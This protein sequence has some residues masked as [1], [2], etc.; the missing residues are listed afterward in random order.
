MSPTCSTM[1][2][3]ALFYPT[4]VNKVYCYCY[5]EQTHCA[6]VVYIYIYMCVIEWVTTDLCSTFWISI[7]VVVSLF[8]FSVVPWLVPCQTAPVLAQ[9]L[10]TP[11][12][13]EPLYTTVSLFKAVYIRYVCFAVTCYAHFWQNDQHPL[14]AI[15]LARRWNVYWSNSQHRKL[16]LE[17]KILLPLLPGL[18]PHDLSI[19]NLLL[20]QWAIPAP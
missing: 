2:T 7:K 9:V 10:C 15:A 6:L 16:T 12:N 1:A 4:G 17:K 13:H 19:T 5:A 3:I 8:S 20:N 18:K 11:Y 14:C